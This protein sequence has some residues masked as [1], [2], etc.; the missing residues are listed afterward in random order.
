[1]LY[2]HPGVP[3]INHT[4]QVAESCRRLLQRRVTNF[5]LPDGLLADTGLSY[6]TSS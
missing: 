1:M 2:S 3:L 6:K 4:R 5:D